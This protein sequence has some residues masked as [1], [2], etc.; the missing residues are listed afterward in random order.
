MSLHNNK[1]FSKFILVTIIIFGLMSLPAILAQHDSVDTDFNQSEPE[2]DVT[3]AKTNTDF[4]MLEEEANPEEK[5]FSM[6]EIC[7][8]LR[9]DMSEDGTSVTT[10]SEG[11][12]SVL[13]Q[14]MK[15]EL[16]NQPYDWWTMYPISGRLLITYGFCDYNDCK[17]FINSERRILFFDTSACKIAWVGNYLDYSLENIAYED[18]NSEYSE[19][20]VS[21]KSSY[22][23]VQNY[24]NIEV[25]K[26]EFGENVYTWKGSQIE[27]DD[28]FDSE[29]TVVVWNEEYH[30]FIVD[31][32]L[33]CIQEGQKDIKLLVTNV[34]LDK[35]ATVK[36]SDN[37]LY[38]ISAN[39]L[40]ML[41]MTTLEDVMLAENASSKPFEIYQNI[42]SYV[43][44]YNSVG[45]KC[46]VSGYFDEN[47][48]AVSS[49]KRTIDKIKEHYEEFNEYIQEW[50]EQGFV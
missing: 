48:Q 18:T 25:Q 31:G 26:W 28:A 15:Q 27:S 40:H 4:S 5:D 3:E 44:Y 7:Q 32:N 37:T 9:M 43:L 10:L 46:L 45:E 34:S 21:S 19:L 16:S 49:R 41:N 11:E 35:T 8:K 14:F 42:A 24:D 29:L 38:Y 13:R 39:E 36:W 47:N 12:I 17:F 1:W 30:F 20:Y 23:F 50:N 22:M 6:D 2:H 33:F